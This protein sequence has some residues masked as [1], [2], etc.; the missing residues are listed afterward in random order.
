MFFSIV[1]M[2]MLSAQG[3][4]QNDLVKTPEELI[5]ANLNGDGNEAYLTQ[6][7]N[8]NEVSVIQD[9]QG[10]NA[11]NLVKVLQVGNRNKTA[12]NQLGQQNQTIVIQ[13]GYKNN[14]TLNL[15]GSDN[16]FVIKQEGKRNTINQNLTNTTATHIELIQQ[17]NDNEITHTQDGLTN[18]KII[19][20][21]IGNNLKMQVN[22]TS[23]N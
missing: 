9:L 3:L 13:N 8:K 17:G 19:V 10:A 21:Q 20:K 6:I 22:Q 11:T 7:G 23:N 15:D 12:V 5:D 1:S 14:Y 16:T 4:T 2:T 18:Q